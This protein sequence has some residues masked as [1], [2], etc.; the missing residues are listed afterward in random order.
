MVWIVARLG[1][2]TVQ[3]G[4]WLLRGKSKF[5]NQL[6]VAVKTSNLR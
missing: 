3:S 6:F 4:T 1:Y 2:N 5:G